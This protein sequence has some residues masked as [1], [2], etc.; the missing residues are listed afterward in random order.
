VA[1]Y[2]KEI[3]DKVAYLGLG[4]GLST[5]SLDEL[6]AQIY[7]GMR[8]NQAIG[9]PA[10][11]VFVDYVHLVSVQNK[12]EFEAVPIVMSRLKKIAMDFNTV[13]IGIMAQNRESNKAGIVSMFTG[14]GSGSLE[15]S[16]DVMLSLA[17]T[18]TLDTT[19]KPEEVQDKSKRSIVLTKGRFVGEDSRVD[20]DFDGKH[21]NFIPLDSLSGKPASNKENKDLNSL[22]G[23][24]FD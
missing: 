2:Q 22:L 6:V 10:P 9:R 17:Y 1:L 16:G 18:E 13:V 23:L 20:F 7:N 4:N 14:R 11:F 24:D 8:Y 21:S 12:N 19:T 3:A 5:S 15:Y